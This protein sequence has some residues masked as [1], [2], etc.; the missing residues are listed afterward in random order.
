[1]THRRCPTRWILR[2][3]SRDVE[4]FRT[5]KNDQAC[6][7]AKEGERQRSKKNRHQEDAS[8][9]FLCEHVS[10]M[11]LHAANTSDH[12]G[13]ICALLLTEFNFT[14]LHKRT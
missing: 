11:I 9:T 8:G 7:L 14:F 13:L 3:V 10:V 5:G 1:M 4:T 12:G 6:V 2:D